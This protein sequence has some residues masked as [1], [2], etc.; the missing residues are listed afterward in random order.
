[1]VPIKLIFPRAQLLFGSLILLII[2]SGCSR[3]PSEI[4]IIGRT[5]GTTYLVKLVVEKGLTPDQVIIKTAIDSLLSEI[6]HQMS[7]W[8]PSSE[9]S[10]FNRLKT[11][12]LFTVSQNFIRVVIHALEV[13]HL[14]AGAFDITVGPLIDL[15]GFGAGAD[16]DHFDPPEPE[17]IS[18]TLNRIG[19][20]KIG[21]HRSQ[22]IKLDPT[23]SIDLSAIAKGYGVDVVSNWLQAE[24]FA[25]FLVEIGGEIYCKGTNRSKLPW[26]IGI[27]NPLLAAIPGRDFTVIVDLSDQA[28]ATSGDYR[29]Y[30]EY[31]GQLFSHVVDP[32]TGYPVESAVASATVVAPTCMAADALATS[33][34]VMG[35]KPGL[36]LIES[37]EDVEALLILR[38]G[39]DQFELL[40]SSGMEV[41][42]KQ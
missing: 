19:Y 15:W 40:K 37:L 26:Q 32:R 18:V 34:M 10:V 23:V 6:N 4:V 29:N 38:D 9:I 21:V 41:R 35:V 28:M 25:D 5:M 1:M 39:K 31:D 11:A 20:R 22:L 16:V 42:E 30:F 33:L 12:Q 14:T 3:N 8:D 27:D 7:S 36:E 2:L 24:G 13:S 17:E